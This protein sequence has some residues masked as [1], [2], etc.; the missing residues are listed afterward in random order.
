MNLIFLSEPDLFHKADGVYSAKQIG[1][2]FVSLIK[3]VRSFPCLNA[4]RIVGP[5]VAHLDST[6]DIFKE[7]DR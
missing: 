3:L 5:D 2:D 7:Y 6:Q 4:S 1:A